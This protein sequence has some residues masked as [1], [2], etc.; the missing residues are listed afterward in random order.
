M[1]R[2]ADFKSQFLKR[3][4]KEV[5]PLA[6]LQYKEDS[7]T[8]VGFPDTL[9]V[10]PEAITVFIEFKKSKNARFRPLQKEW[11]RKL[12][13]HLHYAFICYPENADEVLVQIKELK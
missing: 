5:R 7:S 6:V 1:A 4:K 12:N 8:V 10:M 11:N 3:L 9:V 13:E 2:E